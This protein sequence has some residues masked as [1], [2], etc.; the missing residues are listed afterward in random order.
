MMTTTRHCDGERTTYRT[1]PDVGLLLVVAEYV[2]VDIR[3]RGHGD[4]KFQ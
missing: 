3:G 1:G 2:L 4:M